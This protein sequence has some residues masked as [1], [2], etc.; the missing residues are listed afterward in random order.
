MIDP[1]TLERKYH[2]DWGDFGRGYRD[3]S[4]ADVNL[5]EYRKWDNFRPCY[6][7]TFM[8]DG[9]VFEAWVRDEGDRSFVVA[10]ERPAANEQERLQIA[11][12]FHACAGGEVRLANQFLADGYV[13][14]TEVISGHEIVVWGKEKSTPKSVLVRES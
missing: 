12:H 14:H 5:S 10:F 9:F 3:I 6:G 7:P 4:P 2:R 1:R 11:E 8:P 13:K